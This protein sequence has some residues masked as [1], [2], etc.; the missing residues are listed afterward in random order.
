MKDRTKKAIPLQPGEGKEEAIMEVTMVV[1]GEAMVVLVEDDLSL[2]PVMELLMAMKDYP[3][4]QAMANKQI[5]H[6][7]NWT[8]K[9]YTM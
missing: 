5:D 8:V 2:K 3:L 4:L 9:K 6:T 7:S 1:E